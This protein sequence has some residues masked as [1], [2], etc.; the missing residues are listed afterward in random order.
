MV[1][2]ARCGAVYS[3]GGVAERVVAVGFF[4]EKKKRGKQRCEE[5]KKR[6]TR[7][8]AVRTGIKREEEGAGGAAVVGE[9]DHCLLTPC[10]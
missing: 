9:E 2:A 6:G 7:V 8:S 10:A 5:G 3:G 1:V 4:V